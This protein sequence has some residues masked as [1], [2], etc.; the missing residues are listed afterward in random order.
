MTFARHGD[1]SRIKCCGG[2]G[3]LGCGRAD[4]RFRRR[5]SRWRFGRVMVPGDLV[6]FGIGD[7]IPADVRITSVIGINYIFILIVNN[8]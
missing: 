8:I 4:G 3:R 6:R 2:R 7:R 5:G 1:C